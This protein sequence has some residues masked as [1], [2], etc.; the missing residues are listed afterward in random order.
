MAVL[1]T[2]VLIIGRF[3][4]LQKEKNHKNELSVKM[5]RTDFV[6]SANKRFPVASAQT[7]R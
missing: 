5:Q 4:N 3:G 1:T 2:G 6:G 7:E